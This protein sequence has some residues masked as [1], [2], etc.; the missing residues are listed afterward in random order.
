MA[1]ESWTASPP[2]GVAQGGTAGAAGPPTEPGWGGTVPPET[3]PPDPDAPHDQPNLSYIPALDGVRAFAVLGVMAYHGGIPWLAGGFL[4]VDSFFVLSG[5]LITSLLIAE[6]Q[7]IRTIRLGAFWARRARRLLPAL[8]LVLVFVAFYAA[9]IVPRGTYPDLRLDALSSLFYVANWHFILI[10]SNYF[11]QTGLPSPLTHTWSL[12]IEEQFYLIWPLVVLAVVKLTSSLRVL[13]GVCVVGTVASA[14]EMALLYQPN[15]SLTRLYYGTDTHAQCLLVGASLAV[16]LALVARHRREAGTLST[17]PGTRASR[18][19][20]PG[21]DPGWAAVTPLSR[22]VLAVTGVLGVL[23]S[24]LFWSHLEYSDALLWRGGFLLAALGTAAVLVSAVCAQRS[25]VALA[26]SIAPLRYLGRIS[27]GMYLWHYPLFIW[28]DSAR[29]GLTGYT[30]FGVRVLATVSVATVSFYLVERPVRQGTFFSDW[31][32]WVATPVAALAT[33]AVVIAATAPPAIAVTTPG[34]PGSHSVLY[35]GPKV[36]VLMV[37]D[38][39]ALTLGIG[40]DAA[41][42]Q[43]TYDFTEDDQGQLGCGVA[44]GTEVQL[45]GV[46]NPV[47]RACEP[48]SPTATQW[49][50]QW[51]KW[52]SSF[53]PNVVVVLAGRWEV[54]D[55]TYNRQWTNILHPAYA[56]YVKTQLQ[57]AVNV[58]SSG[59]ARVV[60]MTAPCYDSGEQPDGQPWPEDSADRLNAY[61]RLVEKVAAA[62][63][64]KA[65]SFDLD[66]IACP[67]GQYKEFMGGVQLRESDGV[68]FT[69]AGGTYLGPKIWPDLI[70]DG[71]QQMQGH[72][73]QPGAATAP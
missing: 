39:T 40:I 9:V 50:E 73:T 62:N 55:R 16:T 57:R 59:G 51:R 4:G 13:L 48:D 52:I 30:L 42:L 17:A 72:H 15:A 47:V 66:A 44:L 8:L 2:G 19:R 35:T 43:K 21:G 41:S 22:A 11:N 67:L 53:H 54:L 58:A 3:A 25:P 64:K 31:R 27:Y 5:F 20:A 6:W 38:S 10:G 68:H 24:A 45:H 12:A 60:L 23:A 37:G 34:T 46:T 1:Q 65:S 18:R 49:P 28:I 33:V 63:P 14:V 26:L 69:W 70:A 71:R 7:R 61:N 56:R 29:T 32:A 36:R